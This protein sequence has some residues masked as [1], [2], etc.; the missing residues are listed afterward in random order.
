ML[1]A[2]RFTIGRKIYAII[3]LSFAGF[4]AVMGF[5]MRELSR[6]LEDQKQLELQHL[7][8]LAISF[9]QQEYAEAQAGRISVADAQKRAAA[10]IGELRY[11]QNEY[12]WV[13]DL[14]GRM[15]LHP[16]S[17]KLNG[18]VV[19]D[20]KDPTGKLFFVEMLDVVKRDGRGFVRY[21]WPKPGKTEPQPKL[22]LVA[23]FKP[24]NWVI[25]TGVYI[26]DLDAQVWSV[27]KRT[28]IMA[29]L[30]LLTIGAIA[31]FVARRM[32]RAMRAMTGAMDELASGNFDVVLPGLGRRDEVGDMAGAVEAFKSKAIEKAQQ[33][34]HEK[35]AK[36]HAAGEARK[37]EMRKLADQFE[38]AV[39]DIIDTVSSAATELEASAGTLT[40]T[41]ES[42][43][44]LSGS[45]AAASEQASSNVQAVASATEELSASVVEISRQVTDSSRIADAAVKQAET[46]NQR[47]RELSEAAGRIGD[48]VKLITAIAEQ[49][50]LLA[51][52]ATIE[53]ARAGEAGKGF[54]VVASEVK[55]LATQTAK[56][57]EEISSQIG[58]MQSATRDSVSAIEEIGETINR[59]S[60]IAGSIA[61][62]V[63]QQGAATQEISRNIDQAAKGSSEVAT[64]ITDV[65]RGAGETG[66]AS[67]QVL[68]SAQ[69]LARES[70]HLKM[71]VEKFLVTVRAA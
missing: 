5:Q 46:T 42:T 24:W 54:A 57:T 49:T 53:A 17:T 43:Q 6:G 55:S 38:A 47:V 16:I 48:V 4:L 1:K 14:D 23:G 13:N 20:L 41:A 39:G 50:N 62:A 45:V 29:A 44:R 71:E 11:G 67:T 59:I 12:F 7:V 35:E 37:A 3:A 70:S 31:V 68:S 63:E 10:R 26:D 28:L 33:E 15:V 18:Q 58:A 56:A 9:A 32:S 8:E 52:N 19:L 65:N 30:V 66:A 40:Q 27:A 69:S 25:G 61:A 60:S 34:A 2:F 21:M 51:L 64:N 36:D 22:S